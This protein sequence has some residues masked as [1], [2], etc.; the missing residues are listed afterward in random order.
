[1]V[2]TH[3]TTGLAELRGQN[4]HGATGG[5]AVRREASRKTSP[6]E[7]LAP[8]AEE[9]PNKPPGRPT[10]TSLSKP[11]PNDTPPAGGE[12]GIKLLRRPASTR[13]HCARDPEK[14]SHPHSW[15]RPPARWIRRANGL[16]QEALETLMQRAHFIHHRSPGSPLCGMW[17]ESLSIAG[18][19][20]VESGTHEEL[21]GRCRRHLPTASPRCNFA[22]EF[23]NCTIWARWPMLKTIFGKG[24]RARWKRC[25]GARSKARSLS[26]H[27]CSLRQIA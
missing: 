13:R 9:N 24:G 12:R 6:T 26:W 17:I 27:H 10:R 20:V 8:S 23:G 5:V 4:V 21:A 15:M 22:S 18:G 7:S 16:I 14:S 11:F 3:A 25:S 19:R 2:G 1:M